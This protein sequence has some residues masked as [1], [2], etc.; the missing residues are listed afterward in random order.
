MYFTNNKGEQVTPTEEQLNAIGTDAKEY[1]EQAFITAVTE[2]FTGYVRL[3]EDLMFVAA[4]PT[5]NP[6]LAPVGGAQ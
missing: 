2:G 6:S 4:A 3:S 5:H 1:A